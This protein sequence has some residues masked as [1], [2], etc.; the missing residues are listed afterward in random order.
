MQE[1][2]PKI[3]R[4]KKTQEERRRNTCHPCRRPPR[5]GVQMHED[6]S[7][8]APYPFSNPP[9]PPLCPSKMTRVHISSTSKTGSFSAWVVGKL[10][11]EAGS[12][13]LSSR[14]TRT[15]ISLTMSRSAAGMPLTIV[16]ARRS[17]PWPLKA[18]AK[19]RSVIATRRSSIGHA[20]NHLIIL[21]PVWGIKAV[22]GAA[23]V[24][25]QCTFLRC[26]QVI[27]RCCPTIG[28]Y[29]ACWKLMGRGK[30]ES[31]VWSKSS[32]GL[33]QSDSHDPSRENRVGQ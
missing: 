32:L 1:T 33:E 21:S 22:G 8:L 11:S 10:A 30:S 25:G 17:T 9:I 18:S 29:A 7:F 14:I 4:R 31:A 3:E 12:A 2:L 16:L 5:R 15:S 26:S 20:G 6:V 27:Q 28:S 24:A 19:G 13:V 23:L